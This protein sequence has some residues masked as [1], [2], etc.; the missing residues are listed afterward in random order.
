MDTVEGG[1]FNAS[2]TSSYRNMK[3]VI[4]RSHQKMGSLLYLVVLRGK[5]SVVWP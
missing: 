2:G 4:I 1:K 5:I 3:I